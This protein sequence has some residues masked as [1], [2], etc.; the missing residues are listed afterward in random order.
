MRLLFLAALLCAM[1][2]SPARAQE[3]PDWMEGAW[4]SCADGEET[5]EI[6][7]G[8]GSGLMVGVNHMRSGDAAMFEF[9]RIAWGAQGMTFYSSVQGAPPVAFPLVNQTEQRVVFENPGH[10]FPQRVIYARDGA[11]LTA[12]IEG[13]NNGRDAFVDWRFHPATPATR[14][15]R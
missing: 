9:L 15:P 5:A 10:D 13:R 7:R 4:L 2:L 3:M 8:A 1:P 11:D 12:R 6:W 14:C